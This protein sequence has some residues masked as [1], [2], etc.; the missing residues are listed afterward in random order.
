MRVGI[1]LESSDQRLEFS[2][3]SSYFYGGFS[4][5]Y[6]SSSVKYV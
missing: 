3:F 5:T 1:I 2:K 6:I 4:V